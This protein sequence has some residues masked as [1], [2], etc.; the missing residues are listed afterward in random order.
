[1]CL[2]FEFKISKGTENVLASLRVNL[3]ENMKSIFGAVALRGPLGD[4]HCLGR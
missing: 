3:K 2:K 4:K 1:M